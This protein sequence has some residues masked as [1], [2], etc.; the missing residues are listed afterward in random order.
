[1]KI[2]RT[3]VRRNSTLPFKYRLCMAVNNEA[4]AAKDHGEIETW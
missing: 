1:M 2:A 4:D 3:T